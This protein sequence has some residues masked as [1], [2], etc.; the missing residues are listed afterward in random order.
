MSLRSVYERVREETGL[1]VDYVMFV[2]FDLGTRDR[3]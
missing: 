3:A 1:D 2:C